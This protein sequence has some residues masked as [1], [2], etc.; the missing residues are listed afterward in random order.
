M[1]RFSKKELN[2]FVI[3]SL[4]PPMPAQQGLAPQTM[5]ALIQKAKA[6][7]GAAPAVKPK[8]RGM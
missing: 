5:E 8:A 6:K 4:Q 3:Q 7:R 1:L 2:Q